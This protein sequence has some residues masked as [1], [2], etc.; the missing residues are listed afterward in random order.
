MITKFRKRII[1]ILSTGL[2]GTLIATGLTLVNAAAANAEIHT[3]ALFTNTSNITQTAEGLLVDM[4]EKTAVINGSISGD[5]EVEYTY[6]KQNWGDFEFGFYDKDAPDTLVFSIYRGYGYGN[7]GQAGVIDH[8]TGSKKYYMLGQDLGIDNLTVDTLWSTGGHNNRETLPGCDHAPFEPGKIVLSWQED[9][10]T[11]SVTIKESEVSTEVVMAT[12]NVP[13]FK[14]GY[15]M[16][17]YDS[18]EIAAGRSLSVGGVKI[19]SINGMDLSKD[20]Q[21]SVSGESTRILYNGEYEENGKN[22]ILC[23]SNAL[24]AFE[25][26]KMFDANGIMVEAFGESF[27]GGVD[28]SALGFGEHECSISYKGVSK[29]YLIKVLPAYKG[30]EIFAEDAQATHVTLANKDLSGVKVIPAASEAAFNG[31]F[32]GDMEIEYVYGN[33]TYGQVLF[34][35]Y[36]KADTMNPAFSVYRGMGHSLANGSNEY[37]NEGSDGTWYVCWG[38]ASVLYDGKFYAQNQAF[39]TALE[40]IEY[41]ERNN[42]NFYPANNTSVDNWRSGNIDKWAIPGKIVVECSGDTVTVKLSVGTGSGVTGLVTMATLNLPGFADGYTVRMSN[43]YRVLGGDDCHDPIVILNVNG[44]SFAD[45]YVPYSY[46]PKDIEYQGLYNADSNTIYVPQ[47]GKVGDFI[48]ITN[49]QYYAKGWYDTTLPYNTLVAT[50]IEMDGLSEIDSISIGTK[51]VTLTPVL[52]GHRGESKKYT[53]VVEPSEKITLETNGGVLEERE[54]YYSENTWNFSLPVPEKENWKFGGW[55]TSEGALFEGFTEKPNVTAFT[56]T[57][58][59]YDDV[60]PELALTVDGFQQISVGAETLAISATDVQAYDKATNHIFNASE[61]TIDVK[62]PDS[63]EYVALSA[64]A[65]NNTV[66]GSYFVRYTVTDNWLAQGNAVNNANI[67]AN[68]TAYVERLI[69]YS[70]APIVLTVNGTVQTE[71]YVGQTI[72]VPAATASIGDKAVTVERS[73][74]H[75]NS[76]GVQEEVE[77]KNGCFT[78]REEG[79][80]TLIYSASSDGQIS[81]EQFEIVALKDTELPVITVT[82]TQ[83]KVQVGEELTVPD[84][85]AEDNVSETLNVTVKVLLDGEVIGNG[86]ITVSKPGLYVVCYTATDGAGNVAVKEFQVLAEGRA[87]DNGS[88]EESSFGCTSSISPMEMV[89]AL[90]AAATAFITRKRK[91]NDA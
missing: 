65:F 42:L 28:I 10:V 30:T 85:T 44:T 84:A 48:T 41:A 62:A 73:V 4:D 74:M 11:I 52:F 32:I 31:E 17:M 40:S 55:Y 60:A 20:V 86:T 58:H 87:A 24:N 57:A 83:E 72:T 51:A 37:I 2:C 49:E 78:P 1:S 68:N 27:D 29:N 90:M 59:W 56:L 71:V 13:N 18:S 63:E 9:T 22:V 25:L 88:S 21:P 5:L 45:E 54:L 3:T 23:G 26:Y 35:F 8:S 47:N 80:Y 77:I 67:T 16:K 7:Y 66:Y 34:D 46:N 33:S 82:F 6:A 79:K 14:D 39:D 70:V 91:D 89:A 64:F 69:Y 12:L 50:G 76:L 38:A 15:I 36:S 53:V 81:Y 43:G 75:T 19:L 61:I